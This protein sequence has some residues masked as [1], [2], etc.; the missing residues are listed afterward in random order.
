[1]DRRIDLRIHRPGRGIALKL[2]S[3]SLFVAMAALVK[4]ASDTVPPGQA[5]FFRSAFAIPVI[6]GW[7]ALSPTLE[8]RAALAMQAPWGH[9]RRGVLGTAAMG[10]GFA[11]LS[12]L[13]LYEVEAIS[14]ATPLLV[15]VLAVLLAG[16]RVR[17]VRLT[18]VG[19]GLAG[20]LVVLAPRLGGTGSSPDATLGAL[21]V[22]GSAFCAALAQ[23]FI[24]QLVET[25]GTAA[26][27]FWF[28]LTASGLALLTAPFGWVLP[29]PRTATML[30]LAGLLGGCGQICLTAAYRHAEAGVVAPF[31]YASMLLALAIGYAVFGEVPRPSALGGAALIVAGGALVIW[32]ERQ[33]GL[34]RGPARAASPPP[35]G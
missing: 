10:L 15:V 1:M 6:L 22:L 35:P 31:D 14:Y 17:L 27:V 23:V 32:R 7:L 11:G 12:R 29:D 19:L 18:A 26:I 21:L 28:S 4:A 9:V 3:V 8:L 16:E 25:E 2:A 33:L 5:V 24:R 13:P 34:R 20:V 30:G